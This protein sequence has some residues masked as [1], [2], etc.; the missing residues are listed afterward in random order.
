MRAPRKRGLL[1]MK[2]TFAVGSLAS[3]I[4]LLSAAPASIHTFAVVVVFLVC[5]DTITGVIAAAVCKE[6]RSSRMRQKVVVKVLQYSTLFALGY[7]FTIIVQAWFCLNWAL[8]AIVAIEVG[9][10]LENLA[11]LRK[12]GGISMGPADK[13]INI[14][15]QYFE[16]TQDT[17]SITTTTA[18]TIPTDPAIQPTLSVTQVTMPS[19]PMKP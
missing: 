15:A 11:R 5:V 14:V 6:F 9:S 2:E 8:G 12:Y 4:G 13:F 18:T 3:L 1:I 17:G 10:L 7:T 19:R 16:V